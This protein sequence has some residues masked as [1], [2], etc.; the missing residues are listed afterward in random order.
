MNTSADDHKNVN[1]AHYWLLSCVLRARRGERMPPWLVPV[2]V[3]VWGLCVVAGYVLGK[4]KGRLVAG[5]CLTVILSVVGLVILACWPHTA[6][7]PE[8]VAEPPAAQ[9]AT[10]EGP[11]QN[12]WEPSQEHTDSWIWR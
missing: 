11:L 8:P 7:P 1:L 12:D 6:R 4:R 2:V 5:L 9:P 3:V 10:P